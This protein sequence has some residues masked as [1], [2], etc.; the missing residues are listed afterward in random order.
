MGGR[1]SYVL[2][3]NKNA[4]HASAERLL[5]FH[6]FISRLDPYIHPGFLPNKIKHQNTYKTAVPLH[7]GTV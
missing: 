4:R 3:E 6:I 7:R 5:P 2:V 1:K